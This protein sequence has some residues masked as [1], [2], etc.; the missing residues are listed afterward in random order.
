M[1]N[2]L[3]SYQNHFKISLLIAL[4]L[5]LN[6]VFPASTSAQSSSGIIKG[7]VITSDNQ[8]A[9]FVT[10]TLENTKFGT[11]SNE[12][13][14]FQLKAPAGSHNLIISFVSAET[15]TTPVQVQAG[16]TLILPDITINTSAQALKEVTI[17]GR[18]KS[19][20]AD[21][22]S[23]SLRL[24]E[25]LLEVP[26]NIQVIT[27]SILQ[28]QQIFDMAEG[29]SRNVSGVTAQE[30]WGNYTRLNMRGARVAPFRNGMNVESTWGPLSED[31]SFVERIEF[32]KGPAGFMLA[33]GDPAGFYNVVTKK[34]TGVTKQ[35]VNF[36]VG[37]FNT[38]RA[39]AD[40]DGKI[41]S[42]GKLLYRLNVMGQKKDS[43]R[44]FEFNNRYSI[45]PVLKYQFN[46]KTSLTAE[47][48][49]QFSR[50]SAIGSAYVF[51]AR[52]YK[53]LPR[54]FTI[55]DPNLEP[56]D[57]K[58]NSSFL[59]FEHQL[60]PTWKLTAQGAYFNYKQQGSSLWINNVALNG[61]MQRTLSS[62]DAS[63]KS[64]FGQLFLNG[65]FQTKGIQ[66]RTLVGLDYGHKKYLADWNQSFNLDATTPFNIYRPVYLPLVA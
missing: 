56:S 60:S 64:Y 42:N 51:S 31:M 1:N 40:L 47:Y 54:N 29:V 17:S 62:W 61:D 65:A 7:K 49:Y 13:G 52:P 12:K 37:N 14:N 33:N 63:N 55:A 6:L 11:L 35:S 48:T 2:L 23:Q 43:W 38:Y 36:T 18:K 15:I 39:T 22:A 46:D 3:Y 26:Q 16:Q 20:K 5:L 53:D 45:A 32:V 4:G 9:G 25:P 58:D 34:P 41:S 28:D 27:G 21:N 66:H 50:M 59:T 19:Y 44:D 30:H 10:I 57:M 24:M 8:P